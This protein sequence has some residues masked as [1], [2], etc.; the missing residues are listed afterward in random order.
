M[1]S[2][3]AN[4]LPNPPMQHTST[5]AESRSARG[6]ADANRTPVA[7]GAGTKRLIDHLSAGALPI[8]T[9][10]IA[11][12]FAIKTPV[13]L[14]LDNWIS[15]SVQVASLMTI[16]IPFAVLL[17][18][19]KVD[20]SVGSLLGFSGVVAG[21]TFPSLGPLGAP[22]LALGVG[23]L[24]GM[25]NG[26]LVSW[27]SMSPIIVT[28]G[29]LTLLRGMAQWFAPAPLFEFPESFVYMGFG[30]L[31]GLPI[32]T[33]I[34]LGVLILGVLAVRYL[35]IGRHAIAI[36]VNE[37]AAYLVGIRVKLTGL[38]LYGAVGL[39]SALAGLMSIARIN[40]A[41]SGSLG[42]GVELG[43]LTAVLLGGIPFTGGKGSLLRV[44]LG[45]WL[46]GMLS[47]GLILMNVPTEAGLMMTGVV[48]VL[49]A[50]LNVLRTR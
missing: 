32:L 23:L 4:S 3:L 34:T 41:P 6:D 13:F 21:L 25:F 8:G 9:L 15:I 29:S 24:V 36:G 14:T 47:N 10:L 31:L 18:A 16:S 35:P 12:F 5:E 40:S 28:L 27:L 44:A 39:A 48:L 30:R 42:V 43:V 37:R 50:A 20:L 45:V 17:M 1:A 49:A 46:L 33:W 2:P 26:F 19:G 22:A 38:I 7:G 11:A